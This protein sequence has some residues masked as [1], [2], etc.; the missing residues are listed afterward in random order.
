[1]P[2][3][4]VSRLAQIAAIMSARA[5]SMLVRRAAAAP[6]RRATPLRAGH[7]QGPG[8]VSSSCALY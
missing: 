3:N 8:D 5:A 6:V 4:I 7:E 1:M 2:I